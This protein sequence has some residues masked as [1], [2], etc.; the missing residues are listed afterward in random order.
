MRR[1]EIYGKKTESEDLLKRD[2]D[3]VTGEGEDEMNHRAVED[4]TSGRP[5]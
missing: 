4:E 2:V 3:D 1:K 5:K